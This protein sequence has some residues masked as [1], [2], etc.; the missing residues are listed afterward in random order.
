MAFLL[1]YIDIR[2][3]KFF[4][5]LNPDWSS[6]ISSMPAVCKA[7]A[8]DVLTVFAQINS[9]CHLP[10]V[11]DQCLCNFFKELPGL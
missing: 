7:L 3:V 2:T 11:E 10:S 1:T 9:A 8:E 5:L 6:Q 4:H